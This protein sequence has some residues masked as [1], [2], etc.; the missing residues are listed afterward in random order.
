MVDC[1]QAYDNN[2]CNGGLPS[3]AFQYIKDHG[4][5]TEEK[6]P[7]VAKDQ[8]CGYKHSMAEGFVINGSYNFTAGDEVSVKNSLA[9]YGP[10]S[11]A[12]Q[13]VDGFKNYS[14]GVYTSDKCKNG[15]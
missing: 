2:G 6:Y 11:V 13:V 15:P 3:H 8:K 4:I 12:F 5:T 1:A 10:V 14:T 9:K 7:Y